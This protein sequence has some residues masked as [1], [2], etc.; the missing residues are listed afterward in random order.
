MNTLKQYEAEQ[1]ELKSG[2][3]S[4]SDWFMGKV[5]LVTI[6]AC[7]L[8]AW[9]SSSMFQGSF[10]F[11]TGA[12]LGSYAAL[13]AVPAILAAFFASP[14]LLFKKKFKPVFT[15]LFCMLWLFMLV[16]AIAG[17]CIRSHSMR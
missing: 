5:F 2:T 12:A 10:F 6:P 4:W 16:A 15:T 3:F 17:Q 9:N 7:L 1:A 13:I 8:L 11:F 14:A